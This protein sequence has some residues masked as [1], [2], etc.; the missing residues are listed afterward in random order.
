[1][2]RLQFISSCISL[3]VF[4]A[5]SADVYSEEQISSKGQ[6]VY[7]PIYFQV[8][9]KI[10]TE[11]RLFSSETEEKGVTHQLTTNLTVHN[12]DL[13]YPITILKAD[14]YDSNGKLLESYV[15]D[16]Q[17]I[18]PLASKNL[19]LQVKD[20]SESWGGKMLI[21]WQSESLVN[22]PIIESLTFGF[23]GTHSVSFKTYGKP[24]SQHEWRYMNPQNWIETNDGAVAGDE[25]GL[26]LLADNWWLSSIFNVN[27][28]YRYIFNERDKRP[29]YVRLIQAL[30]KSVFNKGEGHWAPE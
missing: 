14:L 25:M 12:T 18:K 6:L 30:E 19:F 15:S 20:K 27:L 4:T 1:M 2:S 28:N 9:T 8:T 13:K 24:V 11:E 26:L 7:I 17:K 22:E 10:Y 29:E 3:I 21:H 23:G 5:F 16:S